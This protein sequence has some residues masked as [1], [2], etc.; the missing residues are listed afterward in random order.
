MSCVKGEV[1]EDCLAELWLVSWGSAVT[2][3]GIPGACT[4]AYAPSSVTGRGENSVRHA[5]HFIEV[6]TSGFLCSLGDEPQILGTLRASHM[7]C[8]EY[9]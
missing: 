2:S 1:A 8:F 6:K 9:L 5:G 4:S 3:G 7:D